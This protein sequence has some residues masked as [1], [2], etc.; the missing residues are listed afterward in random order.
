MD[1]GAKPLQQDLRPVVGRPRRS[2][3]VRYP[4]MR[5]D[6]TRDRYER[7]VPIPSRTSGSTNS[8]SHFQ[9]ALGRELVGPVGMTVRENKIR[10]AARPG[11]RQSDPWWMT[12]HPEVDGETSLQTRCRGENYQ[13]GDGS[14]VVPDASRSYLGVDVIRNA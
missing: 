10:L 13:Q 9:A 8:N 2:Y 7:Q 1:A 12:A 11:F 6:G 3:L 5:L 14:L 4:G